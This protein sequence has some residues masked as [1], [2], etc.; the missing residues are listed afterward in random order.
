MCYFC[1]QELLLALA[2]IRKRTSEGDRGSNV[3]MRLFI[4]VALP[5]P[6]QE[7][8]E[9][10]TAS[11]RERLGAS[12]M[13]WVPA[14]NMHLTIKFLGEV[15]QTHVPPLQEML[16]STAAECGAFTLT[17][18]GFG[19]FPGRGKPRILWIGVEPEKALITLRQRIEAGAAQLG[20][21]RDHQPFSGHLTIGR[22]RR[23][24]E[25]ADLGVLRSVVLDTEIG[26]IGR[27]T[28][29]SMHLFRSD[30]QPAGPIYTSIFS[31][32]LSPAAAFA[33]G[34]S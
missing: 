26:L 11:L 1:R 31:A 10:H 29:D 9:R 27:A 5:H 22:V 21:P 30:L 19:C 34:G 3:L 13:K 12:V 4:A 18:G 14:R 25:N 24:L 28:I 8:I 7:E 2:S 17:I 23:D 32:P 33:R 6:L 20:Y 16:G 15:P